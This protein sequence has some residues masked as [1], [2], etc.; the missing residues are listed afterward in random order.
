[1]T[2]PRVFHEIF[3]NTLTVQCTWILNAIYPFVHQSTSEDGV[4]SKIP[5][6][7]ASNLPT[8]SIIL[9]NKDETKEV[10]EQSVMSIIQSKTYAEDSLNINH[11][12]LILADGE[13]KNTL[14]PIQRIERL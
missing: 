10:F 7:Y 1:M 5:K 13:S 2:S 3:N 9:C 8:V 4:N 6:V 12:R 11:I 14:I